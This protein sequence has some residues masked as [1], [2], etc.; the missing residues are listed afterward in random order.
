MIAAQQSRM[1]V[2]LAAYRA[3]VAEAAPK[4][5]RSPRMML[6][7]ASRRLEAPAHMPRTRRRKHGPPQVR[8][9]FAVRSRPEISRR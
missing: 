9:S 5:R 3:R 4:R 7:S 6:R 1:D 8:K 2:V